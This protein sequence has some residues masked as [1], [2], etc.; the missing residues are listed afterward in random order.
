[1]ERQGDFVGAAAEILKSSFWTWPDDAQGIVVSVLGFF[2]GGRTRIPPEAPP[3]N[4]PTKV[5]PER[6]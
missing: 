3:L 2:P 6:G 1:M 4:P 5:P